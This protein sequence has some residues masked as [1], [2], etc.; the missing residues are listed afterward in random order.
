MGVTSIKIEA[1]CDGDCGKTILGEEPVIEE[2]RMRMPI[3]DGWVSIQL[4]CSE[5]SILPAYL[6]EVKRTAAAAMSTRGMNTKTFREYIDNA[7]ATG[8]RV[9]IQADLMLCPDCASRSVKSLMDLII[10]RARS[11]EELGIDSG[12]WKGFGV[13]DGDGQGN[14]EDD[15]AGPEGTSG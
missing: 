11:K 15:E 5:K 4:I 3:P 9:S 14:E 7:L 6:E 2:E 13:I 1:S 12:P 10:A 8:P